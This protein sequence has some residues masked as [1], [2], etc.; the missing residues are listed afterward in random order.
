M[1]EYGR[2]GVTKDTIFHYVYA[3]LYDL[4]YRETYALNLR[5]E[6]PRIP[7]YPDFARWAG[8]GKSLMT[9]HIDYRDVAPWPIKRIETPSRRA[10]G[11]Y[12]KPIL[13][14]QPKLGVVAID[15]DTQLADIPLEA[16]TYVLGNRSAIDWVLD[17]HKERRPRNP[18]VTAN[19]STYRFADHKESVIELLAKI[20]RVSVETTT[21]TAAMTGID[22]S[23]WA[24]PIT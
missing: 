2:R 9:L 18:T 3:V 4:I 8:W 5:R 15:S 12:P 14:S 17:Q 13:K 7:F 1:K 23:A 21:I 19:F 16:W 24:V 20:T 6:F 22:R 10:A 11:T